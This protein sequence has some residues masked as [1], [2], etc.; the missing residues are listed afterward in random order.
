MCEFAPPYIVIKPAMPREKIQSK[1]GSAF[2]VSTILPSRSALGG[3]LCD[4]ATIGA[5]TLRRVMKF[6]VARAFI[7][8]GTLAQE[9]GNYT[10]A[11]RRYQ[12]SL[13]IY[14]EIGYRHGQSASLSYLG[15]VASL[16]G[17]HAS[18][19]ELLQES[20]ALSRETGDRHAMAE[21]LKQLGNAACRMGAFS[22]ARTTCNTS[23]HFSLSG[24]KRSN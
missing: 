3:V 17:E 6:G 10:E 14:Q 7:N 21:R 23:V 20:L 12:E 4:S 9:L 11:E 13:E 19:R 8:L 5:R 24:R 2:G 1:P 16:L 18:A 15:Q 22:S